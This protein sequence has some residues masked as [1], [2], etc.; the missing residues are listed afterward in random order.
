ME[1][2]TTNAHLLRTLSN[3]MA[4]AVENIEK[5]L[6]LDN[7]RQRQPASGVVY[8]EDLVITADHVLE[9][10]EDLSIET[11]DKRTLAAQ[12]VGRD[13]ATDLAVLRV[14]GLQLTDIT[15][16]DSARVG[17]LVLAQWPAQVSLAPLAVRYVREEAQYFSVI[18]APMQLPILA[19]QVDH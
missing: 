10:E 7:G 1:Q 2:Q 9:R 6:V 3:Q 12:F 18:F 13:L 17:Q 16:S 4:D 19:S 11:H 14:A 15:T 5:A 8:A